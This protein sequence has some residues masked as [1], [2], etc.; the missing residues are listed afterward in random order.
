MEDNVQTNGP[1]GGKFIDSFNPDDP[2]FIR[3]QQRPANIKVS[4]YYIQV[5]I[6]ENKI[7]K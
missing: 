3:E 5:L 7:L 4:Q 2:E 1:S 6:Y